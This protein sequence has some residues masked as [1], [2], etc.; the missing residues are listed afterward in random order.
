MKK[1]V[2]HKKPEIEGLIKNMTERL[3]ALEAKIDTLISRRTDPAPHQ[4][5]KKQDNSFSQRVLHKAV[6][7]AC[8]K[9]CEVP[10]RPSG[11]RP[12]YCK[13]CFAKRKNGAIVPD[14]KPESRPAE[15]VLVYERSFHKDQASAVPK[16]VEKKAPAAR[17]RR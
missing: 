12:V 9:E 6:C 2:K 11:D 3:V 4:S 14:K 17:R 15:R 7:A 8:S 1:S 16:S 5:E 13:E 10:F